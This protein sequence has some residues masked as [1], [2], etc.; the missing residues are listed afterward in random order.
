MSADL[1]AL[2]CVLMARPCHR[3]CDCY[4][5]CPSWCARRY[6]QQAGLRAFIARSE[7]VAALLLTG[8]PVLSRLPWDKP[9][10]G[11]SILGLRDAV[12]VGRIAGCPS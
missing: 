2:D 10:S 8:L 3:H 9:N 1:P 11:G 4:P 12:T 6:S 7:A 5:G